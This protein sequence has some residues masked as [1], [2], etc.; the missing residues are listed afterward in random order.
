MLVVDSVGSGSWVEMTRYDPGRA[1]RFYESS[2]KWT[3]DRFAVLSSHRFRHGQDESL[4]DMLRDGGVTDERLLAA[5]AE[6][7]AATA[8]FLRSRFETLAQ[9][10][11]QMRAYAGAFEHGLLFVPSDAASIVDQNDVIIPHAILA[12]DTRKDETRGHAGESIEAAID[13]AE[14]AGTL[15]IDLADHVAD[16]RLRIV[17]TLEFD[18]DEVYLRPIFED[19]F[20]FWIE[21]DAVS[22]EALEVLQSN[23]RLAWVRAESNSE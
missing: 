18:G 5:F 23:I 17:E 4:L 13:A 1:N 14:Q 12:W 2:H 9:A 3:N 8:Q 19:P 16:S 20:P 22:P 7:E 15:A 11:K 21:R 6:A 10:W